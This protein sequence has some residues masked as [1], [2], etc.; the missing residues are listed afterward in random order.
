[1]RGFTCLKSKHPGGGMLP[2]SPVIDLLFSQVSMSL[3]YIILYEKIFT[4]HVRGY[5]RVDGLTS[6]LVWGIVIY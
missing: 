1:M 4:V 3:N 2:P 6:V 5:G